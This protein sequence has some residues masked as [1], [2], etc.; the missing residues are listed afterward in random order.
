MEEVQNKDN[1]EF[2]VPLDK[3]ELPHKIDIEYEYFES[4]SDS[5]QRGME[6]AEEHRRFLEGVL[7]RPETLQEHLLRQ[8]QIEPVDNELRSIAETLIQNLDDDGFHKEKPE[9]LFSEYQPRLQ[10]ARL[11]EALHLVRG[12]DPVGT[13]TSDYHESL[14]IQIDFISNSDS[15]PESLRVSEGESWIKFVLENLN[16]VERE[17]YAALAKKTG[18]YNL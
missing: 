5:G 3:A 4:T 6:R 10:E 14:L 13:C 12:L 1:E 18:S 15:L 17:N 11:F 16:L 9:S 8:L 7:C 2:N